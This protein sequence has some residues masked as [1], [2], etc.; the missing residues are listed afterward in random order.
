[1]TDIEDVEQDDGVPSE[2]LWAEVDDEPDDAYGDA[3]YDE[4]AETYAGT[5]RGGP[6]DGKDVVSRYPRGFLLV[7]MEHEQVWLYDRQADGS[8]LMRDGSP[9]GLEDSGRWRAADEEDF[10][11]LVPDMAS[12]DDEAGEDDDDAVDLGDCEDIEGGDE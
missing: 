2:D 4:D 3:D 7:D 9:A 10:D 1:M 11:I 8:F 12:A 5:A 6:L